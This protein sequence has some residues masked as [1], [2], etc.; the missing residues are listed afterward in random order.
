MIEVVFTYRPTASVCSL[1]ARYSFSAKERDMETGLSYFGA[2]Y[3]SSDLSIWLSVDPMSGKYPHQ[4]NY[5]Y[6]SNNPIM[7]VDPNGE[8]EWEVNKSGDICKVPGT[9]QKPDRLF[10][11]D[12]EGNRITDKKGNAKFVDVTSRSMESLNYDSEKDYT[13][14]DFTGD[15]KNGLAVIRFLSK[16]TDVE[17]SFWGGNTWDEKNHAEVAFATLGTSHIKDSDPGSTHL[18]LN[19]SIKKDIKHSNPLKFFYH[20]HPW[21]ERWGTWASNGE[22]YDK[23]IRSCCLL[24]SPNA[25]IGIIHKGILWDYF[26]NKIKADF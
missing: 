6:C 26:N 21:R 17:W 19:A 13:T 25:S 14:L 22:G 16:N 15:E 24:G 10:A 18:V 3:Y 7:M 11:I 2:R 23:S 20:T 8:D 4:S 9:E 1:A 12:D 5:V